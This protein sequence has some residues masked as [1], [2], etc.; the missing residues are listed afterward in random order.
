MSYR[1]LQPLESLLSELSQRCFATRW[2]PEIPWY[3]W[4]FALTGPQ[5]AGRGQVTAADVAE[6]RACQVDLEQGWMLY[7][8]SRAAYIDHHRWLMAYGGGPP[9][10]VDETR[11]LE[12][13]IKPFLDLEDFDRVDA[14][15]QGTMRWW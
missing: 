2:Y 7:P 5:G 10:V 4:H 11:R 15:C 13:K 9:K 3:G 14:L 1:N 12:R 6:L 8:Y